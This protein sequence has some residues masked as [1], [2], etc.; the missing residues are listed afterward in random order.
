MDKSSFQALPGIYPNWKVKVTQK[1]DGKQAGV[2]GWSQPAV[3][4][5]LH[6][7]SIAC[8]GEAS[9]NA[10]WRSFRQCGRMKPAWG[11]ESNKQVR[12]QWLGTFFLKKKK[13]KK[14]LSAPTTLGRL[15]IPLTSRRGPEG[16]TWSYCLLQHWIC[17]WP[18][19]MGCVL[20][21]DRGCR[22]S[23]PRRIPANMPYAFALSSRK[24]L[25]EHFPD[26]SLNHDHEWQCLC[27]GHIS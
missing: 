3:T 1:A 26:K 22:A 9:G 15:H 6:W 23:S 16:E 21:E 12:I 4:H 2:F 5:A 25:E 13:N 14:K 24:V 11:W 10:E 27:L 19:S 17:V 18:L 20:C 8:T 7:S